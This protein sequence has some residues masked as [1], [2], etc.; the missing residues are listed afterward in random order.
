MQTR[1]FLVCRCLLAPNGR[2]IIFWKV[3]EWAHYQRTKMTL[4][5]TFCVH[6]MG[7]GNFKILP[8]I[9]STRLIK[10][11]FSEYTP[12]DSL[13]AILMVSFCSPLWENEGS[14]RF[15]VL[16]DN[17]WKKKSL[18]LW[19]FGCVP[20]LRQNWLGWPHS[21]PSSNMIL[22]VFILNWTRISLSC[23]EQLHN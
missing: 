7:K 19:Q 5:H 8:N 12:S 4:S 13:W 20:G 23:L 9:P 14:S 6:K 21:F 1:W 15:L 2:H 10:C 18:C 22:W 11:S 3:C 17:W 16:L